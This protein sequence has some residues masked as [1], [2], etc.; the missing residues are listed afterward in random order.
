MPFD[1]LPTANLTTPDIPAQE[2]RAPKATEKP[3]VSAPFRPR[4]DDAPPSMAE[5][6][7]HAAAFRPLLIEPTRTG[8]KAG[9]SA[10][11]RVL[12][13]TANFSSPLDSRPASLRTG[14]T[15]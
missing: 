4:T 10:T 3:D 11:A 2:T 1:G 14:P 6:A 5:K 8:K 7:R 9:G 15:C 12:A 13:L